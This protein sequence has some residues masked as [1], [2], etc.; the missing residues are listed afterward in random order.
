MHL[1]S[2]K[3]LS[4]VLPAL[5]T[6][7]P[8][9]LLPARAPCARPELLPLLLRAEGLA[10]A[11]PAGP[12]HVRQCRVLPAR[13]AHSA[14]TVVTVPR[15]RPVPR[16]RGAAGIRIQRALGGADGG[17]AGGN[18]RTWGRKGVL[19]GLVRG[20]RGLWLGVIPGTES[21]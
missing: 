6:E 10:V 20:S 21:S 13:A 9:H 19:G 2:I 15:A 1:E 12:R 11:Q 16:G 5:L 4:G 7:Q 8:R 18:E 3:L 17:V 14:A